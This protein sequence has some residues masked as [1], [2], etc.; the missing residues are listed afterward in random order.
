MFRPLITMIL[1][2]RLR[3]P[4]TATDLR[5]M[6]HERVVDHY[7]NPRNVGSFDKNDPNVGTGLVG[8]PV[9]GDV[10]KLQIRVDEE[11]GKIVDAC[12][13]TF[14]CSSAIASSTIGML[15]ALNSWSFK[16]F[17]PCREIS[18]F[19]FWFFYRKL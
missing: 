5:R 3:S 11:S 15:L 12:F 13:K 16:L 9:C 6:Y 18:F 17:N 10:M 2:Q 14:G 4:V 1:S 19:V 8:A 7:E